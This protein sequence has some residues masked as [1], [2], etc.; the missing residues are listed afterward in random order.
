MRPRRG[1]DEVWLN[2]GRGSFTRGQQ[3]DGGVTWSVALADLDGDGDL[4]LV[5]GGETSGRVWLNDG[6][7]RFSRGQ[8]FPIGRYQSI[9]VGDVTGDGI[10]DII[11]A[12]VEAYRV[13]RA[14]FSRSRW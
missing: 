4:D 14:P 10:A 2:D 9:A 7:G 3:L 11:A 12:G 1:A 8:R 13:W 6:A 5:T